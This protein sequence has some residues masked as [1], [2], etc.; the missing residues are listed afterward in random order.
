LPTLLLPCH[1]VH[2]KTFYLIGSILF[3]VIIL[4][5]GFQNFGLTLS[6]FTIFFSE[7]DTNGTLMI[8]GIAL[9]GVLAGAFYSGFIAALLRAAHEDEEQPG[10]II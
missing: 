4:I 5:I 9:L 2:M 8:F 7:V 3:S 10:G 6:G 1:N